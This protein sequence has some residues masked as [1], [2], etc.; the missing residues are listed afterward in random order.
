[1]STSC[2]TSN[3]DRHAIVA[4]CRHRAGIDRRVAECERAKLGAAAVA[5]LR[6][7]TGGDGVGA[8][9]AGAGAI[10]AVASGVGATAGGSGGGAGGSL[11]SASTAKASIAGTWTGTSTA[12]MSTAGTST[13]GTSTIVSRDASCNASARLA[14]RSRNDG[15]G[16]TV[17]LRFSVFASAPVEGASVF[18][19]AGL[20]GFALGFSV[21]IHAAMRGPSGARGGLVCVGVAGFAASVGASGAGALGAA[22]ARLRRVGFASSDFVRA[23]RE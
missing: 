20:G 2:S 13:A 1:A 14:A 8:G 7:M 23:L 3:K 4:M 12:G 22:F 17:A 19:G 6:A 5:R 9:G 21:D 16:F 11:V 10:G 18:A 15:I